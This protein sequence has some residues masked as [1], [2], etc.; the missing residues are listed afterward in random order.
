MKRSPID[1]AFDSVAGPAW[2]VCPTCLGPRRGDH[3][4]PSIVVHDDEST[5]KCPECGL[6]TYQDGRS[7]VTLG[8]DG[9]HAVVV[10][11]LKT[12]SD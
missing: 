10:V 5:P 4:M 6:A 8:P 11:V 9:P 2:P 3:G 12:P 7:A 1:T